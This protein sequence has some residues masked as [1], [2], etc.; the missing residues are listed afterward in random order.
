[1]SENHGKV[2]WTELMTRDV[3]G[4]VAYYSA[5]CGWRFAPMPTDGG[6][7]HVGSRGAQPVVGVMDMTFIPELDDVPAHWFSYFAVDDLDSALAETRGRGGEV[8]R[9]PFDISGVGRIAI[10]QDPTGAT[11]GLM[12][13]APPG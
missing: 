6:T 10:V 13:P 12:T 8:V 1:M 4:A 2:W 5:V 9:A 7:Y 3:P 11:M